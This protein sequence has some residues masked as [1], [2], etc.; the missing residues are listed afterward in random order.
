MIQNLLSESRLLLGTA[1]Y[2]SP[3]VIERPRLQASG[4]RMVTVSLRRHAPAS[5]GGEKPWELLRAVPESPSSPTPPGAA[6]VK[7]AVTTA[8]LA[9]ELFGTNRIK[10]EVIGDEYTLQPDPF[11][12]VE[13]ARVL[14]G[15]GFEV[16]PYMTED[17]VVAERLVGAG[18][19]ILM[20][21]ASP[22]GSG[23]G[24]ANPFALKTLRARYPEATL[25]VDAGIGKPSQAA[26][27]ME[28]GFDAVLLNTAVALAHE[29]VRMA[30]AFSLAVRAGRA[31][32]E[33]GLMSVRESASASTPVIGT[34]FWQREKENVQV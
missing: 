9:R 21:W 33:A 30:E 25:I 29:P 20:P 26:E 2:A 8:H 14:I 16:F 28:M 23:R 7:E 31:G 17:L 6:Q 5:N 24:I 10:L 34:P 18:C 27:A 22:I 32:F 19:R 12:L 4:A 11:G 1:R 3:E 15:E 13:A